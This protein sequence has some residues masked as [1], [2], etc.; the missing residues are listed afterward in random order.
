MKGMVYLFVDWKSTFGIGV[1][2]FRAALSL[3]PKY[4]QDSLI[5]SGQHTSKG[6]TDQHTAVLTDLFFNDSRDM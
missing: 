2:S 5:R 6:P 3:N 4:R 1:L